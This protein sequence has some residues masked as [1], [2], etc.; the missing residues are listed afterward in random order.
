MTSWN[1]SISDKTTIVVMLCLILIGF[2]VWIYK[3][4]NEGTSLGPN[5]IKGKKYV[6]VLVFLAVAATIGAIVSLFVHPK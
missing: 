4:K 6:G 2:F 3:E 1:P 5:D